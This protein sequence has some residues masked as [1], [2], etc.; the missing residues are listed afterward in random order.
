MKGTATKKKP[1]KKSILSRGLRAAKDYFL[2]TSKNY[3]NMPKRP[4]GKGSYLKGD[5]NYSRM[6]K[7]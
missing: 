2:D 4:K 3:A 6:G 1:I 5:Y 7:K